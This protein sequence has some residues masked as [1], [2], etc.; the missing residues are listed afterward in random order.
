MLILCLVWK[1]NFE[2]T[3]N[4]VLSSHYLVELAVITSLLKEID[5]YVHYKIVV[6]SALTVVSIIYFLRQDLFLQQSTNLLW[7]NAPLVLGSP[8]S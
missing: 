3:E 1:D 6:G 8:R 5:S 7:T 2:F 4:V